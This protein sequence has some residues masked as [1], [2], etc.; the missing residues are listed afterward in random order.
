M[1]AAIDAGGM[2]TTAW[3]TSLG[4]SGDNLEHLGAA[5]CE[6]LLR[7]RVVLAIEAP[8]WV[9]LRSKHSRMTTARTGER[10]SWAGRVG[11]AVMAAGLA[12]LS[13]V[14]QNAK[15]TR[16]VFDE[17]TTSGDLVILEAYRPSTGAG[18]VQVAQD[19]LKALVERWPN[20]FK[21]CI[22]RASNEPVL[23]LAAALASALGIPVAPLDFQRET[24]VIDPSRLT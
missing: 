5:M 8:L 6:S 23:N 20:G 3:A 22:T 13:V 15:P 1:F 10:L 7:T 18:H 11:G 19:I 4:A 14:L 24:M 21:N 12:N 17:T 2:K 9:P 16:V